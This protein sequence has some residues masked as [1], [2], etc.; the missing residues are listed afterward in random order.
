MRIN[1][2]DLTGGILS[3]AIALEVNVRAIFS[4]DLRRLG[5]ES[6][7]LE[8]FDQTNLRALLNRI[9]RLKHWDQQWEQAADLS[10]FNT[11]MNYRD[12]V[13]H[14]ATY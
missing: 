8:I 14:S 13:M 11:I 3:L 10:S 6:V 1:N 12:R 5:V 9:K 2:N 4:R 7:L